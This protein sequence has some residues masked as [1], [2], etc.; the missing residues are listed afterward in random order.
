MAFSALW[1]LKYATLVGLEG[2]QGVVGGIWGP[3]VGSKQLIYVKIVNEYTL[4]SKMGQK[5][6]FWPS[7]GKNMQHWGVWSGLNKPEIL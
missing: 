7:G 5:W 6:H 3:P 1:W 2:T 4:R